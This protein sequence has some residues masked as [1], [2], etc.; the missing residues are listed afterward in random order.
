M[1]DLSQAAL[2]VPLDLHAQQLPP[3]L[4][5]RALRAPT[6]SLDRRCVRLALRGLTA[7]PRPRCCPVQP[8]ATRVQ[9]KSPAPFAPLVQS[10]RAQEPSHRW[11]V[12]SDITAMLG[13][14][15]VFSVCLDT[16]APQVRP[17]RLPSDR[18]V[19]L[20]LIAIPPVIP[21]SPFICYYYRRFVRRAD[22]VSSWNV[23]VGKCR[24]QRRSGLCLLRGRL[25]LPQSRDSAR[26]HGIVPRRFLLPAWFR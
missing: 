16:S 22:P 7:P 5:I 4:S 23:W 11:S 26:D 10:A 14:R 17:I 1:L 21:S 6:H 2:S 9:G 13:R 25:L 18:S 20:A 24:C 8:E 12:A 19:L 3:L 15:L